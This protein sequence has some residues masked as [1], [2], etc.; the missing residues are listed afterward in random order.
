MP[1]FR[2]IE[3]LHQNFL[4]IN[5]WWNEK[6]HKL[7]V[8]IE[9]SDSVVCL[10]I[11]GNEVLLVR[12]HR[13]AMDR[14]D[15]PDGPIVELIAGQEDSKEENRNGGFKTLVIQEALQE[16]GAIIT[17]EDIE[18]INLEIPMALSAGVLTERCTG[19]LVNVTPDKI[20]KGDHVVRGVK[21]EGKH[22]TR[23][24][25]SV[26]Q[27]VSYATPHEDW[28]VYAMAQLLARRRLEAK[29]MRLEEDYRQLQ[30]DRILRAYAPYGHGC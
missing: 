25:M 26:E 14:E 23:V 1:R 6:H 28:R 8:N 10:L 29:V 11:V 20:Q 3:T 4:T 22:I 18:A 7:L 21:D 17:E 15:N 5:T 24:R 30:I 12:Q 27:F 19:Y 16:A 13:P 2:K 9:T